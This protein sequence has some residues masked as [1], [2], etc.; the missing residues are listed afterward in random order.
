MRASRREIHS[1]AAS[2]YHAMSNHCAE[3]GTAKFAGKMA[4]R[5]AELCRLAHC[6]SFSRAGMMY[7]H[8]TTE[9]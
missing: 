4:D 3:T 7:H 6:G 9:C 1:I 2:L 8:S 5:P